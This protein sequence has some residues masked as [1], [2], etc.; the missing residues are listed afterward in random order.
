[1]S[2]LT[3]LKDI[4]IGQAPWGLALDEE[5]HLAYVFSD[6]Y[7]EGFDNKITCV[8]YVNGE[9]TVIS[10]KILDEP[11]DSMTVNTLSGLIY[12]SYMDGG[13]FDYGVRI[14]DPKNDYS[15]VGF[16]TIPLAGEVEYTSMFGDVIFDK[17]TQQL[18]I[19]TEPQAT[20]FSPYPKGS[21]QVI[22]CDT[23]Q[24]KYVQSVDNYVND[25]TDLSLDSSTLSLFGSKLMFF[26]NPAYASITTY[27][28]EKNQISLYRNIQA[29]N[30]LYIPWDVTVD[31][32]NKKLYAA[33]Q[34]TD[35][36]ALWRVGITDAGLETKGEFLR[37][38]SELGQ[39]N[40][41]LDSKT[42]SMFAIPNN[43]IEDD[44]RG[45]IVIV[46]LWTLRSYI[47][48]VSVQADSVAFDEK[49]RRLYVADETTGILSI[50]SVD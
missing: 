7:A 34:S 50:F 2:S 38:P 49:N 44:K 48:D 42:N 20:G 4:Y 26:A 29:N 18:F 8:G 30:K 23:I 17:D 40:L 24:N 35:S 31:Y 47:T 9:Y 25:N 14:I 6:A 37:V 5:R 27:D 10:S 21:F 46:D 32:K 33:I 1:M 36:V 15:R 13:D 12:L 28:I 19:T 3:K 39:F 41:I 43:Y 16:I 45:Y 22:Q 11:S